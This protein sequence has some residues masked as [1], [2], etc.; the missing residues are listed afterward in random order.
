MLPIIENNFHDVMNEV[1]VA[2]QVRSL[3]DAG[4]EVQQL[5][6]FFGK[7]KFALLLSVLALPAEVQDLIKA[8]R[9]KASTAVKFAKEIPK[10]GQLL[11]NLRSVCGKVDDLCAHGRRKVPRVT[12][13]VFT[14]RQTTMRV[15]NELAQRLHV[16]Q[17]DGPVAQA[18]YTLLHGLQLGLKGDELED[19]LVHGRSLPEPPKKKRGRKPKDPP[20]P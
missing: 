7:P 14:G 9:I 6:E 8:D 18:V 2:T 12:D 4:Q 13:A 10:P 11:R 1:D 5:E 17:W 3:L 16:R 15:V 20:E 19:A